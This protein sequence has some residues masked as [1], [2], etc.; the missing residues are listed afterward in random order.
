V[1]LDEVRSYYEASYTPQS[2]LLD[3]KFRKI[4][5][6]VDRPNVF[7]HARSG[8]FALP[9]LKGG[10]Q[11]QAYEMALL[12]ALTLT[13]APSEVAYRA[14]AG[15]FNTH[16]QSVEY[17]LTV[18][19]P[20]ANLTFQPSADAKTAHT[21]ASL[22][23]VLKDDKGE[24][25]SKFSKD[26]PLNLAADKLDAYKLGNLT[27]TFR[28][29]LDPGTYS[30]ESVVLDRTGNKTGVQKSKIV[31]PAPTTKLSLSTIAVVRRKDDL[32]D[33]AISDAFYFEGGKVVPTLNDTLKG[34]SGTVLP[35]Y[36]VVYK[37]AAI[38]DTPKLKMS[39][40]LDGQL[41]GAPEVPLPAPQKDGRIPFIASIPGD[42]FQPGNYEMKVT[43]TQGQ[44]TSEEKVDFKVN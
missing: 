1:V 18:E 15:R 33:N 21:D 36:F 7:V 43:I 42:A 34:G 31:V 8:Y 5:V 25:V 6:K 28:V 11:L 14:A 38:K 35:F 27:Q 44:E 19:V 29:E 23:T 12:K 37:D 41:L 10:E 26:F 40:Y 17:M 30:L 9:S 22:L 13:P 2:D 4:A 16:G 39:F 24:I 32:K 20:I 3:G